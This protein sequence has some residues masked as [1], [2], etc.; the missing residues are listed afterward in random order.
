[1]QHFDL[2]L[3]EFSPHYLECH[4]RGRQYST[5]VSKVSKSCYQYSLI[6]P[7]GRQLLHDENYASPVLDTIFSTAI[8]GTFVQ[9]INA[10]LIM[11]TIALQVIDTQHWCIKLL[12]SSF[13]QSYHNLIIKN[14]RVNGNSVVQIMYDACRAEGFKSLFQQAFA[15]SNGT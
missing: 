11:S 2:Q 13:I 1:M 9:I 7:S 3:K 14:P 12:I 4:G 10:P 15:G 5:W 8:V 6:F